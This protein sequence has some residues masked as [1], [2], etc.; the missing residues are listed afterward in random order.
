MNKI[1]VGDKIEKLLWENGLDF[2]HSGWSHTSHLSI[3]GGGLKFIVTDTYGSPDGWYLETDDIGIEVWSD[4]VLIAE[5]YGE[6]EDEED[7]V[8]KILEYVE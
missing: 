1:L 6:F 7:F 2:D 5:N 8:T 3:V 4:G